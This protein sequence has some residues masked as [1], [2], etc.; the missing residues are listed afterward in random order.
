MTDPRRIR[1]TAVHLPKTRGKRTRLALALAAALAAGACRNTTD[2]LRTLESVS[3]RDSVAADATLWLD[4]SGRVWIGGPG[5]VTAFDSTGQALGG[6]KVPLSGTPQI[7]WSRP[8]HAWLRTAG[9]AVVVDAAGRQT[10][11]RRSGAPVAADPRGRW[12]YSATGT[13][14]VL[15][16]APESL[17]A[18]WGW[19]DAG[20]AVSSLAVS[21]LGDRV[22]VALA[23]SERNNVAPAIQ[24]RDALSGRLLSTFPTSSGIKELQVGP[25]GTLYGVLG[26]SVVALR[27]G[28]DGLKQLWARELGGL[29][30]DDPNVLR[31]SPDGKRLAVVARGRELHLLATGDGKVLEESK[32]APRDA[33]WDASGRLWV[34]GAREIRIVR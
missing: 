14:S 21:P 23:G 6:M 22:Y 13:G 31:V 5:R 12:I 28:R 20:S 16:L 34:L 11:L 33:A 17:G 25:D 8:G 26:G 29:D 15:G 9:A 32:R 19:P 18:R 3:L 24:V 27:H 10:G 2:T 30:R 7:L 1:P 4:P